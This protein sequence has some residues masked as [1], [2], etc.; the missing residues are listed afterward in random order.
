MAN[1]SEERKYFQTNCVYQKFLADIDTLTDAPSLDQCANSI[2]AFDALC[3]DVCFE[4]GLLKHIE[5]A[6][7]IDPNEALD[8]YDEILT[9]SYRQHSIYYLLILISDSLVCRI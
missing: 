4:L 5:L 3:R 1:L 9:T 6:N 2:P 7:D 8:I